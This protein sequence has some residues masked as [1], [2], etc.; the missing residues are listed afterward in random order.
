MEETEGDFFLSHDDNSF[1][2][3]SSSISLC[4]VLFAL[5]GIMEE[6]EGDF[7]LSHDDNCFLKLSS[8]ISLC[9]VLFALLG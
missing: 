7:F 4:K 1:L 2:K 8:S 6:T 3:L 9:K 5:L